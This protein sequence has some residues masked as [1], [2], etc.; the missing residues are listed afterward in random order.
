MGGRLVH[1]T[2]RVFY[3]EMLAGLAAAA[4]REPASGR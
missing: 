3:P 2:L 1:R 4:E